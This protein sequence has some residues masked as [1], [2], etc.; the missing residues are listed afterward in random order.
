[1]CA[2]KGLKGCELV[3]EFNREYLTSRGTQ[4]DYKT[5]SKEQL[6]AEYKLLMQAADCHPLG[7]KKEFLALPDLLNF[8]EKVMAAIEGTAEKGISLIAL[9]NQRLLILHKGLFS[10]LDVISLS[11]MEIESVSIKKAF[12][13]FDVMIHSKG[14]NHRIVTPGQVGPYLADRINE[15]IQ[16]NPQDCEDEAYMLEL[17]ELIKETEPIVQLKVSVEKTPRP[18]KTNQGSEGF[19]E[20]EMAD[21]GGYESPSGGFLTYAQFRVRGTSQKTGRK[22]TVRVKAK[23]A[24]DAQIIAES[25]GILRPY[26]VTAELFDEPTEAQMS[27]ATDLGL[28]IPEG[29]CK[30]DVSSM[31][32]RVVDE[33][34][35][36]PSAGLC[37]WAIDCGAEFS[38]FVGRKA[39]IVGLVYSLDDVDLATFYGYCVCIQEEQGELDDPRNYW[40]YD[41]IREWA[42]NVVLDSALLNSLQGRDGNDFFCPHKGTKIYKSLAEHLSI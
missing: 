35:E 36:P 23:N 33:D 12:L 25:K 24:E 28:A 17:D 26:E 31:L 6:L 19:I 41:D 13:G 32:S 27:F 4:M 38:R 14:G 37:S 1:M 3:V 40:R 42:E 20:L 21:I 22:N 39:M 7:S 30:Q 11:L 15:A 8:G 18:H 29:A 10:S 16:N 9:T 2:N 5:A 34:Q